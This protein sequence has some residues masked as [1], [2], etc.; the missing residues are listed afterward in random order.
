MER[1][2]YVAVRMVIKSVIIRI[3]KVRAKAGLPGLP[4][5]MPIIKAVE[6]TL[7][8]TLNAARNLFFR[9]LILLPLCLPVQTCCAIE[10][11]VVVNSDW[12]ARRYQPFFVNELCSQKLMNDSVR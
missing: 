10:F 12:S 5:R 7:T 6:I 9:M 1:I 2:I 11:I 3:I 8:D 4:E